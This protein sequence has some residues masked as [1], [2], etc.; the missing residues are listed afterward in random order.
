MLLLSRQPTYQSALPAPMPTMPT[1]PAIRPSV[2]RVE[3][4]LVETSSVDTLGA[5]TGGGGGGGGAA[6]GFAV[7]GPAAIG[8]VWLSPSANF[9]LYLAS[10]RSGALTTTTWSPGFVVNAVP[11]DAASSSTSSLKT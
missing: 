11:S 9:T 7:S 8:S 1:P 2:R 10:S 4:E 6:A 3:P 5:T